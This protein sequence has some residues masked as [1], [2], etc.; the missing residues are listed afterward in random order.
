MPIV[1]LD[2]DNLQRFQRGDIGD[3]IGFSNQQNPGGIDLNPNLLELRIEGDGLNFNLPVNS[4]NLDQIQIDG[5]LPVI[6][7]IAPITNLPLILGTVEIEMEPLAFSN[8]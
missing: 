3:R 8:N 5:L 7:N 4:M 6:I 1:N 2:F